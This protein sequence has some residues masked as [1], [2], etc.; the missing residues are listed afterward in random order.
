MAFKIRKLDYRPWPVSV[1]F[2]ECSESTGEV[3]DTPQVFIGHFR[4]FSEADIKRERL[5]IFGDE[6]ADG[7]KASLASMPSSEYAEREAKFFAALM[8]GWAEVRDETG[9]DIP[10][11][12]AALRD[13]AT[14]PDGAVFRRGLNDA[15]VEIRFG[16]AP[17]KNSSA[18]PAPGRSPAVGEAAPA[19]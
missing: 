8:C 19:N 7:Y 11:S 9:A 5:E 3:S 1:K 14:G 12:A 18:S 2:R 16:L 17:A 4:P 13:L 6:F 10:F 15:V